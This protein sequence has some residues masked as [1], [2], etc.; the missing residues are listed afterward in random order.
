MR[1]AIVRNHNWEM[2]KDSS[3]AR[4]WFKNPTTSSYAWDRS[5][6]DKAL[7]GGSKLAFG[8]VTMVNIPM[9]PAYLGQPV[10]G[11]SSDHWR[12]RTDA[13]DDF[14]KFC[15]ELVKIVNKE[16]GRNV[17][18]FEVLNER[19]GLYKD[20]PAE[21]AEIYKLAAREMRK[22]DPSIKIGGPA[23]ADPWNKAADP[24]IKAAIDELDFV[25][26]HTYTQWDLRPDKR[27]STQSLL[28]S[29]AGLGYASARI[30]GIVAKY[31]TRKVELFHNEYNLSVASES[32]ADPRLTNI[33]SAVF[34]ALAMGSIASSS[35][36]GAMA[37][38]ECDGWYG[39]LGPGGT[40]RPAAN[41]FHLYNSH[42]TGDVMTTL[43]SA[44]AEVTPF[45]VRSGQRRALALVNR[46]EASSREVK[47]AA[48]GGF[49]GGNV[50][51]YRVTAS[52]LAQAEVN[53]GELASGY[54]L[55]PLSVTVLVQGAN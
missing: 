2:L 22:V 55:P 29:A 24:F 44:P 33:V 54:A 36:T 23:L 20:D 40:R 27:K 50:K 4:G 19:E 1:P 51:V 38:N 28:N 17:R 31:T 46:N 11:K 47:V 39:K 52:G 42:M 12:L 7:N 35:A 3:S 10:S 6:I 41:V 37:W 8:Q 25:S 21:L 48:T 32:F 13:Y 18:Y 43:S 5:K 15:A 9:W 34:D 26:Y 14:A 30:R 49:D 16:Q 53:A 45:A